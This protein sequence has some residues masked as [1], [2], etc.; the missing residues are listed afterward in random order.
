MIETSTWFFINEIEGPIVVSER[1]FPR[2]L[3]MRAVLDQPSSAD[4]PR[5]RERDCETRR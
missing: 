5:E 1:S 2:T 4:V 3:S